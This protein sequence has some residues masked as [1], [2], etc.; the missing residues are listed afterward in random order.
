MP[1]FDTLNVCYNIFK[2]QGS[3]I[4]K[5]HWNAASYIGPYLTICRFLPIQGEFR[6]EGRQ[7][8][9]SS[10]EGILGSRNSNKTISLSQRSLLQHIG[11]PK[12][13]LKKL[14]EWEVMRQHMFDPCRVFRIKAKSWPWSWMFSNRALHGPECFQMELSMVLKQRFPMELFMVLTSPSPSRKNVVR[15]A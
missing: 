12:L 6:P 8:L 7:H 2:L 5:N 3:S 15:L 10:Y 13:Y 4:P 14:N 1:V 11:G 9:A